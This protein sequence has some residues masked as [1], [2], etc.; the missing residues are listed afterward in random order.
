[1]KKKICLPCDFKILLQSL[2]RV[3]TAKQATT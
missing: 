1:V 3:I 2:I